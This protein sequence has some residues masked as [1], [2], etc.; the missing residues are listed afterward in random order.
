VQA[1]KTTYKDGLREHALVQSVVSNDLGEYRFFM[2]KPGQ[3]HISLIPPKLVIQNVTNQSFSIPLLYPGTIDPQAATALD[4]RVGQTI[5]GVDFRSIPI[6]NRR[7]AGG[8]QGNGTDGVDLLLSP[9]NGTAS[10]K[11]TIYKDTPNPSFQFSDI[12]PGS[13]MLVARTKDMRTVIPLDVRN[14]DMLG[15]RLTLG[16]GFSIPAHTRIEG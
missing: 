8:V 3:Y 15:T 11:F 5:D 16:A 12:V 7:I 10:L 13:Y 2:L 4:L 1:L 9:V 14:A 6:K